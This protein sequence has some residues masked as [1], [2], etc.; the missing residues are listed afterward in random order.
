[1]LA[2]R[3]FLI[4]KRA[5]V[6]PHGRFDRRVIGIEGLHQHSPAL[7]A[8]AGSPGHL[9]QQLERPLGGTEVGQVQGRVG[10]DHAHQCDVGKIEPLGDHLRAHQD[11]HFTVAEGGQCPLVAAVLLHGVGVHPQAAILGESGPYFVFEFLRSQPAV[12]DSRRSGRPGSG[13]GPES[14]NRSSGTARSPCADDASKRS[15]NADTHHLAAGWALDMRGKPA[16]V[17]QQDYLAAAC[18]A[19]R[20]W[21]RA[22]AG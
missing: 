5:V 3:Q 4:G 9:H 15:R 10:V 16:A 21:P 11:L 14:R 18:A 7:F 6:V 19:P 1:M 20:P 17:Q 13:A 12:V 22:A 8:A 2:H